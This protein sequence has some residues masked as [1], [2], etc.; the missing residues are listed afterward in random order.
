M[1]LSHDFVRYERYDD[2]IRLVPPEQGDAGHLGPFELLVLAALRFSTSM[3]IDS[4]GGRPAS[5]IKNPPARLLDRRR[6]GAAREPAL[7]VTHG[8]SDLRSFSIARE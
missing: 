7:A 6:G 8:L 1:D 3:R 5:R 2:D 4:P